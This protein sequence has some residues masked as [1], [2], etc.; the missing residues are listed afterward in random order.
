MTRI[1]LVTG[2][3]QGL[4]AAS[5]NALETMGCVVAVTTRS[6][7]KAEVFRNETGRA[8]LAWDVADYG[9]CEAGVAAVEEELGPI[10][11][12]AVEDGRDM[13]PD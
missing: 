2:G 13:V 9:A 4:G 10:D 1:A 7:E 8:A 3:L 11:L 12:D 5:A 6:R